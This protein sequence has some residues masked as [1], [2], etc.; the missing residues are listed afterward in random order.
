M[1]AKILG[2]I[3]SCSLLLTGCSWMDGSYVHVTPHRERDDETRFDSVSVSNYEELKD[4]MED[5]VKGG[6][7]D[8][9]IYISDYEPNAV[10]NSMYAVTRYITGEFPVGAYAVETMDYEI[11]TS[12][13]KPAIAVEITY[14]HSPVEIQ[15]IRSAADVEQA[16]TLVGWALKNVDAGVV[17]QIDAYEPADFSQIVHDF[18]QNNPQSVMEVPQVTQ[19][20]Y[21]IGKS[22]VV[23]LT[24]TYQTSRE[25]LRQMQEQVGSVFEA[26]ELYVSADSSEY[27]KYTHLY[28]FLM[29]RFDYRLGTSIT[30]SYSLLHHGVGDS[31]AFAVT[32][33]AM[34]R[35]AD[36]DCRIVTGT[37]NGEPWTWNMIREGESYYHVDLLRCSETGS[38]QLQ[39]DAQMEGYIWDYSAYPVC[40][41][42]PA[43]EAADDAAPGEAEAP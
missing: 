34:C 10:S 23:E 14:R 9:V 13:G 5:V 33:A 6:S 12:S 4:V 11:G 3:L 32:Y 40:A 28:S 18:A 36:L 8:A 7:A 20:V 43:K 16:A 24:F 38:Y 25:A 35:N 39:T 21:G 1:K 30:P 17:L 2:L 31:R 29:D 26:A 37:R 42:A 27:Q 15:Q 19:G 22:R 41:G